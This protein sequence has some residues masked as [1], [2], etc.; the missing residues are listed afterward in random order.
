MYHAT[1]NKCSVISRFLFRTQNNVLICMI[2]R[3]SKLDRYALLM[4][5]TALKISVRNY[6][7]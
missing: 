3:L 6:N 1:I 4:D 2:A 5:A 7:Q